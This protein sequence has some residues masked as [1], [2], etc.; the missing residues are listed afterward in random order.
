[1][2]FRDLSREDRAHWETLA[3]G[4]AQVRARENAVHLRSLALEQNRLLDKAEEAHRK[5]LE[6]GYTHKHATPFVFARR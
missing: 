6:D 4:R 5:S 2:A 3:R 1:M